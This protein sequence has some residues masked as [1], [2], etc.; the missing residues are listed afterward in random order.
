MN[1]AITGGSGAIGTFVCD[2]FAEAGHAVT[3]VDRVSPKLDVPYRE[4]DLCVLDDAR[5]ALDGFDQIVHL[6]AIPD[7]FNDPIE[8]VMS[9]N[10]VSTLNVFETAR[11]NGTQRVLLASSESATGFGIHETPHRP[12]YVPIDE[13]HPCWPHEGYSFTKY[14]GE[15]MG[16]NYARAYGLE[17]IALRWTCVWIKRIESAIARILDAAARQAIPDLGDPWYGG[18]IAPRDLARGFLASAQ[19]D[20]PA[21]RQLKFDTFMLSARDTFYAIPTLE[22]LKDI[23]GGLPPVRDQEYFEQNPFASV[24]DMRKAERVLGWRPELDWREFE[25]WETEVAGLTPTHAK[26]ARA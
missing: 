18:N 16:E 2:E 1:V 7:P 4:V 21:A 3:C 10:M 15:R 6:A 9:V 24:F 25:Q 20:F 17:V 11:R 5:R 19:W 13:E 8:R 26:S 14:F 22:I 23:H 12:E